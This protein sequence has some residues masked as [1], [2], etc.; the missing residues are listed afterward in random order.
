MSNARLDGKIALITGSTRGIGEQLAYGFAREGAKVAIS[1]R[2]VQD[3]QRVVE[4]IRAAGGT[5][6][7][8]ALEMS[9]ESAVAECIK[10]VAD[11]FGGLNV[12]VNNAMPSEHV[13]GGTAGH[14]GKLIDKADAAIADL[15]T[16]RW[17]KVMLPGLDGLFWVLKYAIPEMQKSGGGSIVNISSIASIQGV[18]GTDAYTAMKG[19]MNS[20]TRS[21]AVNYAADNIRCNCL[22]GGAFATPGA[23]P[24]LNNPAMKKAF[25]ETMLAK[26]IA[27]PSGMVGPAVF[28][29]SDESYYITGQLL[30]VD[31][32]LTIKMPVLKLEA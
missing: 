10:R 32:G 30:P 19:A 5:A 27:P 17:R 20:L 21:I 4:R 28:F 26:D 2:N 7:F 1:G 29:A 15:T 6:V 9:E 16:E 31:G 24:L 14:D 25:L 22:V 3:G 23:A 8:V 18:G 11:A 12:L 13:T